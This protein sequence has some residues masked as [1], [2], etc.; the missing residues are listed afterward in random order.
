MI[1]KCSTAAP[2]HQHF[3]GEWTRGGSGGAGGPGSPG[4]DHRSASWVAGVQR[5][6]INIIPWADLRRS[7]CSYALVLCWPPAAGLEFCTATT[8]CSLCRLK[9]GVCRRA[10]LDCIAR[11]AP[12]SAEGHREPLGQ[13]SARAARTRCWARV[14]TAFLLV[15]SAFRFCLGARECVYTGYI[16]CPCARAW[17]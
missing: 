15:F 12:S 16:A 9:V 2:R 7:S 3:L 5:R 10:L 17:I 1:Y 13:W 11:A 4:E 8:T 6:F 14:K